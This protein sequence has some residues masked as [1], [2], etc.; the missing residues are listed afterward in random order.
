MAFTRTQFA[1]YIL[2]V[3]LVNA[4]WAYLYPHAIVIGVDVFTLMV[5]RWAAYRYGEPA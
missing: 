3:G 2:I 5:L 4:V 1:W